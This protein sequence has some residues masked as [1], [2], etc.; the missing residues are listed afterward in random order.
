M[1]VVVCAVSQNYQ[2]RF[3]YYEVWERFRLVLI[4][5]I[6]LLLPGQ[7]MPLVFVVVVNIFSSAIALKRK[8]FL[9]PAESSTYTMVQVRVKRQT[10]HSFRTLGRLFADR[11]CDV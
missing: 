10:T 11:P 4:S 2:P 7:Y 1:A 3:W 8:P 5:C 6:G 9:D